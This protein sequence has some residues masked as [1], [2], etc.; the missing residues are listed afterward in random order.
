MGLVLGCVHIGAEIGISLVELCHEL[1]I[2]AEFDHTLVTDDVEQYDRVGLCAVPRIVVDVAEDIF[3]IRIPY[4]PEVVGNLLQ[5]VQVFGEV[6]MYR[7]LG[8][9]RL[10]GVAYTYYHI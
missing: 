6:G 9:I 4:P 2:F 1:G 3:G 8:P 10:I 5:F 7:D